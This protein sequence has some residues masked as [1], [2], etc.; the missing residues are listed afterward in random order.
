MQEQDKMTKERLASYISLR[1]EVDNQ[2]ERLA[3]MRN[4]EKIPAMRESDGSQHS[5]GSGD[6]MERAIIRRMEY[7]DRVMPQIEAALVEMETIEQ[8]I[9]AVADPME[10]EVLRL[11]YMEGNYIRH[12]PWRDVALKLFGDDDKRHMVATYRLHTRALNNIT[13]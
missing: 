1:L 4:D 5:P 3:R 12:M 7:E 11:R 6:R 2:L 10:R 9:Y 8:A 13:S